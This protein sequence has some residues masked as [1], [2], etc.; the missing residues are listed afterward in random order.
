MTDRS[1]TV[2]RAQA[3]PIFTSPLSRSR[4][5]RRLRDAVV[6]VR[7]TGFQNKCWNCLTYSGRR[8]PINT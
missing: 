2:N 6:A 1:V 7:F 5:A 8:I 3:D 4:D